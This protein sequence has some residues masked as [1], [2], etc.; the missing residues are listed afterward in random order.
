MTNKK[1]ALQELW[2]TIFERAGLAPDEDDVAKDGTVNP[3][4][5]WERI[6]KG[7]AFAWFASVDPQKPTLFKVGEASPM[8]A[9]VQ[10]FAI[11]QEE[12]N[13]RVYGFG[14]G[15]AVRW[16]LSKISPTM[17]VEK[18]SHDVFIDAVAAE[19]LESEGEFES[20]PED[21][22]PEKADG[23]PAAVAPPP[24]A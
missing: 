14:D 20:L 21:K 1:D 23:K 7:V 16:S 15:D 9:E 24:Q 8:K 18:L 4:W 3:D 6:P 10:V 5:V 13:V 11:F 2:E 12:A 19:L 22:D 17:F